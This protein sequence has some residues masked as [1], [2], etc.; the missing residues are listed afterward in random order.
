[1][2]RASATAPKRLDF[3]T[4]PT[5]CGPRDDRAAVPRGSREALDVEPVERPD[6]VGA[7]EQKVVVVVERDG[8]R[9]ENIVEAF[10]EPP[11]QEQTLRRDVERVEPMEG[12]LPGEPR[13]R[14][15]LAG[16]APFR[17]ASF[18]RPFG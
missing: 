16:S 5:T 13:E 14:A 11:D 1:M 12:D 9:V 15:A 18:K 8:V 17:S 6:V 10:P 7:R 3:L 2:A 4:I